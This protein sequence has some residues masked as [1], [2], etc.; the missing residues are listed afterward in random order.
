MH[1]RPP[2]SALEPF[3]ECVWLNPGQTG[4][5]SVRERV[6]PTGQAHIAIRPAGP[7]FRFYEHA[8]DPAGSDMG[9]AI[10]GGMRSTPYFKDTSAETPSFG[11]LLK[12]G[13]AGLVLGQPAGMLAERHLPL[14]VFWPE[15][16]V[17]RLEEAMSAA[18]CGEDA[19]CALESELQKRVRGHG[20]IAPDIARALEAIAAGQSVGDAVR[21]AGVSHRHFVSLFRNA[22]GLSPKLYSRVVRLGHVV[23]TLRPGEAPDWTGLAADAGYFDQS[24]FIR[25][26]RAHTGL[27]PAAYHRRLSDRAFHVAD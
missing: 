25:D 21:Q 20:G 26:F 6:L 22:V 13:A 23:R 2:A 5:S 12:P 15:Q 10:A 24:H 8:A 27:A 17:A 3:I 9:H 16:D 1:S 14:C 19:L 7:G 11:A 4:G 18:A